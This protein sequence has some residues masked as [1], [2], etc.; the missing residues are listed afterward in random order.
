M[1]IKQQK[2]MAETTLVQHISERCACVFGVDYL[3]FMF[4][5]YP[6]RISFII[7]FV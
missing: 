4:R 1:S 5:S 2:L 6:V 3:T 7:L